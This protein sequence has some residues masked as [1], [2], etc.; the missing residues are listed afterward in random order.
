MLC[1]AARHL[2]MRQA[3]ALTLNLALSSPGLWPFSADVRD[4][5]KYQHRAALSKAVL[6]CV[7][8][9]VRAAQHASLPA[10]IAM[11]ASGS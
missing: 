2:T 1:S 6:L 10:Q 11:H 7:P 4:R 8:L 9:Q 5:G 3:G